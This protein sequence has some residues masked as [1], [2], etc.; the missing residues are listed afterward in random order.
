VKPPAT[1]LAPPAGTYVYPDGPAANNGAD[2][3]R[4]GVGLDPAATYWRV[5]WTTLVEPSVP[6]ALFALD[7]DDNAGTGTA[8]WPAGAGVRSAG[9]DRF[10]LMSGR[11]AWNGA[12]GRTGPGGCRTWRQPTAGPASWRTSTPRREP[13]RSRR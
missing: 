10:L 5:D 11:D 3:F 1:G 13:A 7:T 6:I 9:A 8:A 4:V 2:I 12:S